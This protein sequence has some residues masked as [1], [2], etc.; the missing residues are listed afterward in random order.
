MKKKI[1]YMII[2]VLFSFIFSDKAKAYDYSE[3]CYKESA[4]Q[5]AKIVFHEQ[6]AAFLN[7]P[8]E[9]FFVSITT[10]AVAINNANRSEKTLGKAYG[11]KWDKKIYYLIDDAYADHSTYRDDNLN[12]MIT[13]KNTRGK[14]LYISALVLT[15]K[16][17]FP[18][19]MTI[20]AAPYIA[21]GLCDP[22][23][24]WYVFS[25]N[26]QIGYEKG[27]AKTGKDIFG[28]VISNDSVD[29]YR[30]LAKSFM[31][32]SYSEYTSDNVCNKVGNIVGNDGG[33]TDNCFAA[34]E[35]HACEN[36]DFVRVIFF[37]KLIVGI[38]EIFIPIGLI[39]MGIIDF[40]KSVA[41][42]DEKIQKK[43]ITTFLKRI[44]YA[45]IVFAVPWIVNVVIISLGDLTDDVNY[46][47]CLENATEEG[48]EKLQ[49]EYDEKVDE[50]KKNNCNFNNSNDE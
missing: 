45:I 19:N 50:Y 21:Q 7:N 44:I 46:T 26:T 5:L 20:Q 43:N 49:K 35:V 17:T 27:L 11:S 34:V 28:N 42:N 25:N 22:S 10:A 40:S 29:R 41:T 39:I 30:N 23:G 33:S 47:D 2:L 8:E 3:S 12:N 18:T 38:L 1:I 16:Y 32:N 31:Q 6:G 13:D 15:G 9:N 24:G 48:I 36:P 37:I 14:L 4:E